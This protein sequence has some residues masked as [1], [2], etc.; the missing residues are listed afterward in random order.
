MRL[1]VCLLLAAASPPPE[2][3]V[4]QMSTDQQHTV[5]LRTETVVT[6]PI[7]RTLHVPGA[8]VFDP[9]LT[10]RLRPFAEARV[11]RLLVQPGQAVHAG[12]PLAELSSSRLAS[13]QQSLLAQRAM[14]REAAAGIAVARAA[15]RRG[16]ILARGGSLAW[17]EVDRRRLLLIEA[18]A[19]ADTTR[20]QLALNRAELDELGAGDDASEQATVGVG[21]LTTPIAGTVAA[22]AV[23]PGEV[24]GPNMNTPAFTIAD[25]SSVEALA[26][27]QQAQAAQV[28]VG[29]RAGV[30]LASGGTK[31]W[32]GSVV[33]IGASID[34][35]SRT[36][37][38]RIRLANPDESLRAGMLV[39]VT[40][41]DDEGRQGLIVPP[42]AVQLV[43]DRQVVFTP[44]GNGRFQ[45]HEVSLGVQRQDWVQV[46][47]GVSA[48]Q[49]VV[50]DGSFSL[51][52]VMQKSLLGGG[53]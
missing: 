21:R 22:I 31:G 29:E 37:P 25:L 7:I 3:D 45:S 4:V 35:T 23:T 42:D 44:L 46:L 27:V 32:T 24:V 19:R 33:A 52:S 15:L 6:Q 11:V 26:Q 2:K 18:E 20:A 47:H 53:G 43:G 16:E 51:K 10:A 8:I 49:Q 28:R 38:I 40:V 50:T 13:A 30:A 14:Q 36:L 39:D 1:L 34:P 41:F 48:G 17:A 12:S 5:G 9:S